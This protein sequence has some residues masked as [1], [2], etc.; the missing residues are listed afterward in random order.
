MTIKLLPNTGIISCKVFKPELSALGIEDSKVIYLDQN[1]HRDPGALLEKV[2]ESL[3]LLEQK[4]DLETIIL[5]YGFCGGGLANLSSDRLKLIIPLAHD[6]I[7]LITG[8]CPGNACPGSTHTF[9]L[10]PG[11]IDHGLTPYTEYFAAVEKYGKDDALW[12]GM[13]MLKSYKE[14][15]LVETIAGLKTHHRKYAKKMAE[16][17]CLEFREV[18]A[19]KSWLVNLFSEYDGEYARVIETGNS[20]SLELYPATEYSYP[21]A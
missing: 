2:R 3:T 7:P 21:Q 14:V 16:L 5:V 13:E 11:W 10:S 8:A 9:Y 15:V 17:F 19:D 20:V 4:K 12:M 18:K 6:C 1:L